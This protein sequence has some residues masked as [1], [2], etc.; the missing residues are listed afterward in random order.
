MRLFPPITVQQFRSCGTAKF[1]GPKTCSDL[2]QQCWLKVPSCV[3]GR[4]PITV[5]QF[6]SCEA[7]TFNGPKILI[8]A[9]S[10]HNPTWALRP[11]GL[12]LFISSCPDA[13]QFPY[14]E[15]PLKGSLLGL[16]DIL[17]LNTLLFCSQLVGSTTDQYRQTRSTKYITYCNTMVGSNVYAAALQQHQVGYQ[18]RN[19]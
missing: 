18:T 17:P 19:V 5:Q 6:R 7:L 14:S 2:G 10:P 13:L 15:L 16:S 9:C 4:D 1:N 3:D 12:C 8:L 11:V